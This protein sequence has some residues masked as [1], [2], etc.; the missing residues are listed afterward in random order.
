MAA[1][2]SRDVELNLRVATLG[3]D[4]IKALEDDIR[5]LAAEGKIA[6]D[7][8]KELADEIARLGQNA[9]ALQNFDKLS[10][11]VENLALAADRSSG[12]MGGLATELEALNATTVEFTS[13]EQLARDQLAQTATELV[14]VKEAINANRAAR[15]QGNIDEAEYSNLLAANK[16]EIARLEPLLREQKDTVLAAA[17]ATE[18]AATQEQAHAKALAAATREADANARA[19]NEQSA[20][21]EA[22]RAQLESAGVSTDT[23]AAAEAKVAEALSYSLDAREALVAEQLRAEQA[24]LAEAE[25]ATK[26]A[27]DKI[28]A[29]Q[30][31]KNFWQQ[32]LHEREQAL[33]ESAAA[34][35][36]VADEARVANETIANA[37]GTI[38]KKSVASLTGEIEKVHA[39]MGTLRTSGNLTGVELDQAMTVGNQRI[40]ELEREIRAATGELTLMD[41]AGSLLKTTLGQFA[42]GAAVLDMG[43]R[44]ATGFVEANVAL[45]RMR[46][47]LGTLYKDTD[48][49]NQQIDFLNKVANQAGV[50]V[51]SISGSFVKFAASMQSANIP[52]AQSNALF[53]AVTRAAGTLGLDGEK[54]SNMLEALSQMASKGTVALEELRGQLG[55]ALPGALSLVS[56]GLGITDGELIKLVGSGQLAARDLFPALTASL[57]KMGGEVNT[58]GGTWERFKNALTI[59]AQAAGD[60]GWTQILGEGLRLLALALGL[61]IIPLQGFFEALFGVAN[62]ARTVAENVV[63][64]RNPFE[65]VGKIAEE[66]G[67]RLQKTIDAFDGV[68]SSGQG[69]GDASGKASQGIGAAGTAAAG[70]STSIAKLQVAYADLEKQQ[71]VAIEVADKGLKATKLQA[72]ALQTLAKLR[73]DE[74]GSLKASADAAAAEQVAAERVA[75]AKKALVD[76]IT[77]EITTIKA[78]A[79]AKGEDIKA[80]NEQIKAIDERLQKAKAEADVSQ[81][82]ADSA[83]VTAL[84][85]SVSAQAA[86]DNANN[87][88]KMRAAMENAQMVERATMILKVQGMATE[89]GVAKARERTAAATALYRDA[90]KDA[91]EQD[92]RRI[93]MVRA[94]FQ[95]ETAGLQ[96]L[97]SESKARE[98]SARLMGNEYGIRVEQIKQR[99]IELQ[100][101]KLKV[102]ATLAEAS[103]MDL[104]TDSLI[105]EL[106]AKGQWTPAK[107]AE[108]QLRRLNAEI[109]RKEAEAAAAGIANMEKE[110][111][112]FKLGITVR[113]DHRAASDSVIQGLNGE[114][115]ARRGNVAAMDEETKKMFELNKKK[116][117]EQ[118]NRNK[119]QEGSSAAQAGKTADGFATNKDGAA[120][121][122]FQNNMPIDQA[123]RLRDTHGKG[124]TDDEI[125]T[126]IQQS[127]ALKHFA[128]SDPGGFNS[129]QFSND[130]FEITRAANIAKQNLDAKDIT[131]QKQAS[132][133]DKAPAVNRT[134]T[135]NIGGKTST[136]GVA[137]QGDSDVLVGMLRSLESASQS[138]ST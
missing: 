104:A 98:Q 137:S 45:Q 19:L 16:A 39:A 72:E 84:A 53:Q 3:A 61:V 118:Y 110:L 86:L 40:K 50:S 2:N 115:T 130:V 30:S 20:A 74:Q 124:M 108:I 10:R 1:N 133:Q 101:A 54:V 18:A 107:E 120:S 71:T 59:S 94:S 90:V 127:A 49:A 26:A 121:G 37:F 44:M 123:V 32:A 66:A 119:V 42:L 73:G 131:A 88:D 136:I 65:G 92:E 103:A 134:V 62:I 34:E 23:L 27:H 46:L 67:A 95:L 138:S 4:G 85:R 128:D 125:R 12:N 9:A 5:R 48:L 80:R 129:P 114:I 68:I 83:R 111:Q 28:A 41:R 6:A 21:L 96:L 117:D 75:A 91:A 36:K 60:S 109:K 102:T 24:T 69:A 79:A 106:I 112:N 89:E 97:L 58:L 22:V 52:L 51:S 93:A 132:G 81:R 70:A 56:Q 47:G 38:G 29:E 8:G 33:L 135:V 82:E 15:K 78:S 55:D 76:T 13:I 63:N 100:L 14:T 17:A 7:A 99:E 116:L 64:L 122:T 25:A 105:Q 57:Q 31:Y 126:G 87:V 43:S 11:E 113:N 77:A 35:R